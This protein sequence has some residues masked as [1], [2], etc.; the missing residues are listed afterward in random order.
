MW[1]EVPTPAEDRAL[2][3]PR[4]RLL[5][6]ASEAVGSDQRRGYA[7][8]SCHRGDDPGGVGVVK[9]ACGGDVQG[10]CGAAANDLDCMCCGEEW[11]LGNAD[12]GELGC[13]CDVRSESRTSVRVE[14]RVTV[15]NQEFERWSEGQNFPDARKLPLEEPPRHVRLGMW[16]LRDVLGD[17]IG[18]GEAAAHDQGGRRATGGVIIDVDRT[19]CHWL[20]KRLTQLH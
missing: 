12:Y 16:N 3:N 7:V 10:P 8:R 18:A 20:G 17:H 13:V 2:Q 11:R 19:H 6:A 9:S 4:R 14:G 15:D 1:F 5:P